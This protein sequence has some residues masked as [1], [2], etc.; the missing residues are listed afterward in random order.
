MHVP[1]FVQ[2][3]D[4]E[5]QFWQFLS[6]L[7]ADDLL[8]ELIQNDLDANASRTSIAFAPDRLTCWGDG[9]VV[10]E[11][12]WERLSFVMGAGAKVERKRFQIGVKNHGLKACFWLGDEIVVRSN[13]L[14][15][16][17]TL[18]KDGHDREPS[19]GTLLAPI[20]DSA[21]QPVAGCSI[22]VPYREKELVVTKGEGLKIE[23]PDRSSLEQ[24]FRNAAES[25]PRRLL[26]VVRPGRHDQ[27]TLCLSHH[28][29][30]SV[31]IHWRAKRGRNIKGRSRRHYNVFG[32]ECI[33]SSRTSCIPS[34]TIHE[35]ACTFRAQF[36]PGRRPEIPDFFS[37]DRTSFWAEIAWSTD[38]YSKPR[39][40]KGV[41]RYPIG[42]A[43]T[44]EAGLSGVGVNFSG[45]YKSDAE[46]HGI[47]SMGDLNDYI[48]DVCKDALVDIVSS[49]LVHRHSAK[50]MELYMANPDDPQD[51]SL[52]DLVE[53]T[54][55]ARA[56]PLAERASRATHSKRLALGPRRRSASTLRRVVLPMFTWNQERVSSILSEICPGAEDQIDKHVPGPILSCL[57]NMSLTSMND[58]ITFDK[59]DVVARLQPKL[60][61]EWFPWKDEAE[62]QRALGNPSTAKAYLDVLW[63]TISMKELESESDV[64]KNIYLPDEISTARPLTEMFSGVGLPP[65]LERRD[66][67]PLLH[68][69][70]QAHR[71]LKSRE[72]KPKRFGLDDYLDK[73]QLQTA[74]LVE[75][76]SFWT[77]LRKDWKTVKPRQ[78]LV[79]I[80]SLPVWPSAN[81]DLVP[82][83][84]LCEPRSNRVASIMGNA[85][86]R[87]ARELLRAGLVSRTG[88][89]LLTIRNTPSLKEFELFL[90]EQLDRFPRQ[91]RLTADERREFHRLEWDLADLTSSSPR[92]REHLT[93][94]AGEYGMALDRGG[95]L[96]EPGELVRDEGA[97]RYLY[98]LNR[99]TIDRP[100]KLL[101]T[102]DGWKPQ[103][104]PTTAQIIDTIRE[105]GARLD[106]HVPRIQEY[107]KQSKRENIKP[108]D[109][110]DVPCIPV[111]GE[112]RSPSE[113]ALPRSRDF[114]GDWK[115]RVSVTDINPEV[116]RLYA[117]VG[118]V[119]GTPNSTHSMQFFQW[120]AS[121]DADVIV[122]HV[123]QVLRHINHRHG[124]S[125][126]S[127]EF[128]QVPFIMVEQDSDTVRLV[129][130]SYATTRRS[131]VVIPDFEELEE[132]IK[133]HTGKRPVEVTVIASPRVREPATTRLREFGIRTL[134]DYAGEPIEVLGTG[135]VKP[136]QD[137]GHRRILDAL[138]SG[139]KGRQLQKRLTKLDLD[140]PLRNNW[141]DR[142]SYIQGI[143]TADS[144][145]AIYKLG[146]SRFSIQVAGELDRES[147]T[148]WLSSDSDLQEAFFEVVARLIFEQ[149]KKYYGSV[150]ER[151]Y[152]M[153][154]RE[155]D[156][157]K[158][159][160]VEPLQDDVWDEET[161]G[162]DGEDRAPSAT[163]AVHSAPKTDPEINIPR[164]GPIPQGEDIIRR[165]GTARPRHHRPPAPTE[166]AQV[167]DLKEKQY[168]WHCQACLA[169]HEPRTL[170][171]P[172]SYVEASENRREIME[173]HHCDHVSAGG[174]RHAGNIV[175]LCHHHHLDLGDAVT[176]TEITR[177]LHHATSRDLMF[178]SA[179]GVSSPL[180]GKVVTIQPPQRQHQVALFFTNE[181]ARFWL[182][183][184]KEEGLL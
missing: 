156:P 33:I 65:N 8:V 178:N 160:N 27:Y 31:E 136:S 58:L 91:R 85:L 38:K 124:P 79:R 63:L 168:A 64:R 161:I 93:K 170:A 151:A 7:H 52:K 102:I 1:E 54:L 69:E 32:R 146:R 83:D 177:A 88:R 81:G 51:E 44:S 114:W 60:K 117:H 55:R 15:I 112:P 135:S 10:S 127:D 21:T 36:P 166:T 78:T 123:D 159:A 67:A 22:T 40:I 42:Y 157:L 9:D 116:Q 68:P 121:Q 155:H 73:A 126:W 30:G 80:V 24:L 173:A 183:K 84:D 131:R 152:R 137:F 147:G 50:A 132:A 101:D 59:S 165:G 92:L 75:R 4:A 71:A 48:D 138:Q 5:P 61:A 86:V 97:L 115:V 89:G 76:R 149:P 34:T 163:R 29:L 12:G 139:L 172:S 182:T 144:I 25:L 106:A 175:L 184:A 19:P 74:S 180:Q 53:R 96:R 28:A 13:G 120:L 72:W 57:A 6:G 153:D 100:K 169:G 111:E 174:A 130:K 162:Q 133:Q 37:R 43:A 41:R 16:V 39:P 122:R 104:A 82:L 176:R 11:D 145:E 49:Y 118:V 23:V 3:F 109:L 140:A 179:R 14:R 181:H 99:H 87:P 141:R 103:S 108:N 26:G 148:L 150:L 70:L 95:N 62:W 119:S 77:W 105:D 129:T 143:R 158:D 18:Y 142:L 94:L 46:R 164:P 20:P 66:Y 47:S 134:S 2:R 125:A 17:Q 171:P 90:A 107:L 56:L 35:H 110:L 167:T 154:M 98:L 45:P 128:P 113:L